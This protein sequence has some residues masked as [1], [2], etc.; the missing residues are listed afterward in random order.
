[1]SYDGLNFVS[2]KKKN[3]IWK[4]KFS[5]TYSHI[6]FFSSMQDGSITSVN[7]ISIENKFHAIS[8]CTFDF[9]WV[10]CWGI[11]IIKVVYVD[12]SSVMLWVV[13]GGDL[14]WF[15]EIE[16]VNSHLK[17]LYFLLLLFSSMS[18]F[19]PLSFLNFYSTPSIILLITKFTAWC[20]MEGSVVVD[21]W[22]YVPCF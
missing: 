13:K 8:S 2:T 10:K 3:E 1:L 22:M 21:V 15:F 17:Y 19:R 7:K 20:G 12:A 11:F 16:W 6:T 14:S 4:G 18:S 9:Y 5:Y